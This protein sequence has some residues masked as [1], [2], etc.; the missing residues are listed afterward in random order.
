MING[1]GGVRRS[2]CPKINHPDSEWGELTEGNGGNPGSESGF[3]P[4]SV[5]L[6]PDIRALRAVHLEALHEQTLASRQD[7][8]ARLAK[9]QAKVEAGISESSVGCATFVETPAR[10]AFLKLR[11]ERHGPGGG[12]TGVTCRS[13]RSLLGSPGRL[14]YKHGAPS[15]AVLDRRAGNPLRAW[16]IQ[17][18]GQPRPADSAAEAHLQA[19]LSLQTSPSKLKSGLEIS[20]AHS[21]SAQ[22]LPG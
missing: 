12:L 4:F 7:D 14:D 8:L 21:K 11:R 18:R 20:G 15:G 17:A 13:L 22:K 19:R 3:S 2:S 10:R 9:V 5:Q 1:F 16:N 6:A